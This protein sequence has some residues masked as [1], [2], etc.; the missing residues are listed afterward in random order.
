MIK[1]I[2][3]YLIILMS[4]IIYLVFSQSKIDW[5][6]F[7]DY[8]NVDFIEKL[9]TRHT[10]IILAKNPNQIQE[11]V[12][13]GIHYGL[14]SRF[15]KDFQ[16]CRLWYIDYEIDLSYL[17]DHQY[18]LSTVNIIAK[19]I[20]A[21]PEN[22]IVIWSPYISN[23]DQDIL[24]TYSKWI[25]KLKSMIPLNKYHLISAVQDGVGCA[26]W[27]SYPSSWG[28]RNIFDSLDY[29][30]LIL[31]LNEH[32]Q[33][34]YRNGIQATV[35]IELFDYD[36]VKQQPIWASIQ[37]ISKQV[38]YESKY[39]MV[40]IGPCWVYNDYAQGPLAVKTKELLQF[41]EQ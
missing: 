29:K 10:Y 25:K 19:E 2:L 30:K 14:D 15:A 39:S 24:F 12:K 13:D 1:K 17:W 31:K 8:R 22:S 23:L 11:I 21:L 16:E 41:F 4:L 7:C 34:C 37:R 5:I 26:S 38:Q 9:S 20:K 6:F 27:P 18:F 33:A 40:N 35:N 32:Y 36:S 3:I 28:K